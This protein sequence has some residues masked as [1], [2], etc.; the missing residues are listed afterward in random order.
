M[1]RNAF[2]IQLADLLAKIGE[3]EDAK[4]ACLE[5]S[6]EAFRRSKLPLR[7]QPPRFRHCVR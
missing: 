6:P 2:L 4:K 3:F 1:T 5:I 7:R